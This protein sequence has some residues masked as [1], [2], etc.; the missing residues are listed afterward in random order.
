MGGSRTD[1]STSNNRVF[2][3][4]FTILQK[5]GIKD[6][7]QTVYLICINWYIIL[8]NDLIFRQK[9]RIVVFCDQINVRLVRLNSSDGHAGLY[10]MNI[11]WNMPQSRLNLST[12]W[13]VAY[14]FA[15]KL[16]RTHNLASTR[17]EKEYIGNTWKFTHFCVLNYVHVFCL[18]F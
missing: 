11:G 14:R 1:S 4:F 5:A 10:A 8:I 2:L 9:S 13:V 17:V 18:M 12:Y 7:K 15:T 16:R 6:T 3:N